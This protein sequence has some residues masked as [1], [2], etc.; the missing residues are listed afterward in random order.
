MTITPPPKLT[1][2]QIDA[3][4][5]YH[6]LYAFVY[7][8]FARAIE[9]ARDAAWVEALPKWRPIETAPKD[10][11]KILVFCHWLGVCG[12]ATWCEDQFAKNPRPFWTHWGT[13]VWGVS[14]VRGDQPTHWMPLP[15]APGKQK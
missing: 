15:S 1:D 12:P 9:S 14:R 2:E 8:P 5:E 6:G 7:E 13:H 4:S 3:L 11:T 10:G